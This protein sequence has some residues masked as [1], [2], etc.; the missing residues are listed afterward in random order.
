MGDNIVSLEDKR[1]EYQSR[2][3]Y[4]KKECADAYGWF[5][6]QGKTPHEAFKEAESYKERLDHYWK[7]IPSGRAGAGMQIQKVISVELL[8]QHTDWLERDESGRGR[9]LWD[10]GIN[11]RDWH[12]GRMERLVRDGPKLVMRDVV[13]GME[14]LDKEWLGKRDA[15]YSHYASLEARAQGDYKRYNS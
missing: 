10:L 9:L 1:K 13:F 6:D 5:L 12:T 4:I 3:S 7:L 15:D 2:E 14:R 11:S 8:E